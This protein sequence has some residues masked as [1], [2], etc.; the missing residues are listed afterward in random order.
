MSSHLV[1]NLKLCFW[2]IGGIKSKIFDKSKDPN[3]L[4]EIKDF[5]I[6]FLAETHVGY[7]DNISFPDF[8]YFPI[9]REKS[10]NGRHFGGLGIL[11]KPYLKPGIKILPISNLNYHWIILKK[12]FFHTEDDIYIC[13]VYNPP[14]NSPISIAL[15]QNDSSVL[16]Q[17]SDD[18]TKYSGKGSL[19]FCGDFNARVGSLPDFIYGDNDKYNKCQYDYIRDA[20]LSP[21]VTYDSVIDPRGKE[22]LDICIGNSLR[23]L[24]GRIM[25]DS[26]GNF[27]C[28]T[29]N[30]CSLV[31]YVLVSEKLLQ[32]I[33]HFKVSP[34]IPNFSDAHC[35]LS[36]ILISKFQGATCSR[37]KSFENVP[38]QYFWDEKSCIKL[39]TELQSPALLEKIT[40]FNS[41]NIDTKDES[42]INDAARNFEKIILDA[43]NKCL[44][45][46]NQ[47]KKKP[48]HKHW[49]DSDLRTL[50]NQVVQKAK[51]M[52]TFPFNKELRNSFYKAYR[53]YN[54]TRKY[55]AKNYKTNIIR[56]IDNLKTENPKDYWKLI[57]SLKEKPDDLPPVDPAEFKDHFDCLN[58]IQDKFD[59]A[60]KKMKS[61][62]SILESASM[63][64]IPLDENISEKEILLAIKKLKPNKSGGLQLITND[65]L[66]ACQAPLVPS[67]LKLFNSILSSGFYPN[68]WSKGY[69]SPIFK[70]GDRSKPENYRGIAI[71]GCL[72]KLFNSILNNR[73]DEFLMKNEIISPFQVGFTKK[74]RPADHIFVLKTVIDKYISK[75]KKIYT[76]FIDFKKAFD[77]VLHEAIYIKLLQLGIGGLFFNVIRNMYS[78]SKLQVKVG[79]ILTENFT[80]KIGVR[81]GDILSPNL[82]K[83]FIND[84]PNYFDET[85]DPVL[86]NNRKISCLLYADDVVIMSTSHDGLQHKLNKLQAFCDDW[87]IEVNLSKTKVMIFNKTGKYL[88]ENFLFKNKYLE[89]AN[90]YKYLGITLTP[91][92]SFQEAKHDLYRKA[93]K[94]LFKLKADYVSL[95]PSIRSSLHIF[96][97]TIKAIL[98]YGAEIWGCYLPPS[99]KLEHLCDWTKQSTFSPSSKMGL[100]FVKYILGLNKKSSN[101]GAMSEVG[102]YPILLDCFKACIGYW[103]RLENSSTDLLKD[104]YLDSKKL[105]EEGGQSW[106]TALSNMFNIIKA[107]GGNKYRCCSKSSLKHTVKSDLKSLYVD[108]WYNFRN[109]LINENGKLRT[110]VQIKS[111]FGFEKYLDLLKEQKKRR[112]ITKFKISS[113]KLRIE[114]GRYARP[115]IPLNDRI[116]E[117]CDK[118]EIDDELHFLIRCTH[119]IEARKNLFDIVNKSNIN[120]YNSSSFQKIFWIL[121]CENVDILNSL[122]MFLLESGIT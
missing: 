67:L 35:K 107:P 60:L 92:G 106:F 14:T 87:G 2:N 93:L 54:K 45:R 36:W 41:Q 13:V 27:T 111:N 5:D 69:L 80:S 117:R 76:C 26:F 75:K 48:K 81:Q 1:H 6:V 103:Y 51:L 24:N 21:R 66:K 56:Q 114:S 95:G 3:F 30:G 112:S 37:T 120:F 78:K 16:K 99:F 88:R 39:Q 86:V 19:M 31:D 70:S 47:K 29:P 74:S 104:A 58:S 57:N 90:R 94:A 115:L 52:S 33:P 40:L 59:S 46:P 97:H 20:D 61:K 18:I 77:S 85:P 25:G 49:Y 79:N 53:I 108:T 43:C 11:Y 89:C 22:L 84:L 122:S 119:F 15:E 38:S 42:S 8:R 17:L 100:H 7:E 118:Q 72:G 121:N 62:L 82:F 91:S 110:Y 98:L 83:I 116:C 64:Q 105:A 23:M 9:C 50:R 4:S 32:Q 113:H 10:K 68:H 28:F 44:K 73:L 101:F 109:N 102:R 63:S 55:K 34:F 71:T 65:M 96:D 12:S